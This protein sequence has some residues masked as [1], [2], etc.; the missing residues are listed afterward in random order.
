[1]FLPTLRSELKSSFVCGIIKVERSPVGI[2]S[3]ML[4]LALPTSRTL[5]L[6]AVK[7]CLSLKPTSSVVARFCLRLSKVCRAFSSIYQRF[8]RNRRLSESFLWPA[9]GL[10]LHS[11]ALAKDEWIGIVPFIV[12]DQLGGGVVLPPTLRGLQSFQLYAI[13]EPTVISL[14]AIG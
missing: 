1:M 2:R 7:V 4:R 6:F 12:A 5:M 9:W 8:V 11:D 13:P 14:F 3:M 10:F